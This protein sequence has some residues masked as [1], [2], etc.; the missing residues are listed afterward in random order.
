MEHTMPAS[1]PD[2]QTRLNTAHNA[3]FLCI[4]TAAQL[5]RDVE[6][7]GS[8]TLQQCRQLVQIYGAL[9]DWLDTL[10]LAGATLGGEYAALCGTMGGFVNVSP[11]DAH[12]EVHEYARAVSA[13]V[14]GELFA[15]LP[16]WP[17]PI[18]EERQGMMQLRTD[19]ASFQAD[20]ANWSAEWEPSRDPEWRALRIQERYANIRR[21]MSE[22][23][24]V[25]IHQVL[26][27]LVRARDKELKDWIVLSA[28]K[29]VM[30]A[31]S[32]QIERPPATWEGD[33]WDALE[34]Q[35]RQLLLYM[36]GREKAD[37][38]LLCPA[39]WGKEYLTDNGVTEAARETA[40][41]KANKFLAKRQWPRLLGKVRKEPYLRWE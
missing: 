30:T 16:P 28:S 19:P 33:D 26:L 15:G 34:P 29:K 41:S 6:D 23:P 32:D 17:S 5:R 2:F 12:C 39:V 9:S 37:L 24:P 38:R 31:P 8:P 25:D 27:K 1:P 18:A 10:R 21:H 7:C 20:L 40:T 4:G 3:A 22:L 11:L 13:A 14:G 35:V 36:H